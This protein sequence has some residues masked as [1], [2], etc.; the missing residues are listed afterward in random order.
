MSISGGQTKFKITCKKD[1]I[2]RVFDIIKSY[3]QDN[4]E[5]NGFWFENLWPD[6]LSEEEI[7]ETEEKDS[8]YYSYSFELEGPYGNILNLIEWDIFKKIAD[9]I[10]Y[11]KLDVYTNVGDSYSSYTLKCVLKNGKMDV[12]TPADTSEF[13]ESYYWYLFDELS[14]TLFGIDDED[15]DY[16]TIFDEFLR[17]IIH[18]KDIHDY[19]NIMSV[20]SDYINNWWGDKEYKP[21]SK[22]EYYEATKN[23]LARDEF[24]QTKASCKVESYE[25]IPEKGA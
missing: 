1:D 19:D 25:Y 20:F 9:I 17:E 6:G 4:K 24:I 22:T 21:V 10:P 15:E 5:T 2:S 3:N 7:E 13:D 16:E 12:Q 8:G 14:G 23:L 11:G 18:E